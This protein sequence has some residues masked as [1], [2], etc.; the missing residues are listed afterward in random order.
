MKLSELR[1]I[2][3]ANLQKEVASRKEELMKL[4]FQGAVGNLAHPHQVKQL[5]K[6]VA[7]LLTLQSERQ[8]QAEPSQDGDK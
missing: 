3:A 2:D 8:R 6:E 5:R 1:Q 4:R 7:Q